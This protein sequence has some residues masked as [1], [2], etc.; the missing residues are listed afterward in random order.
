[1]KRLAARFYLYDKVK[2]KKHPYDDSV[3]IITQ[4]FSDNTYFIDN[5]KNSY[6]NIKASALEYVDE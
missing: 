5:G 4:T 2:F 6:T 3:Y 1:M